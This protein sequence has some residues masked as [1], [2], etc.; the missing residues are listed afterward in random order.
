MPLNTCNGA[1]VFSSHMSIT[2]TNDHPLLANHELKVKL[3]TA[4]YFTYSHTCQQAYVRQGLADLHCNDC[5]WH[6]CHSTETRREQRPM[7]A[8]F[9]TLTFRMGFQDSPWNVCVKCDD[10]S[11]F[12]VSCRKQMDTQTSK[13]K[14]LSHDCIGV[15]NN[16][17]RPRLKW[18]R[19]LTSKHVTMS[20]V[21]IAKDI[22]GQ[23]NPNQHGQLQRRL[24]IGTLALDECIVTYGTMMTTHGE[25]AFNL[26]TSHYPRWYRYHH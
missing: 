26:P 13:G 24:A 1:P 18:L 21:Y 25:W 11:I 2:P 3:V 7:P 16:T 5:I 8:V 4:E 6:V 17:R 19:L 12:E 10:A 22:S 20:V 14:N 15:R 23:I 9:V